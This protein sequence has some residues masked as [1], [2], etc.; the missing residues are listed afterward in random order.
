MRLSEWRKAAPTRDSMSNRVMA[1]LNPVLHDLGADPNPESWVVW[2][3]DPELRYAVLAPTPAGLISVAVRLT[4]PEAGPR[5]TAKLVRWSKLSV[6]ELAV[7]ASGGHR[8]VGV[9][10]EG[11]VLKGLDQEADRICEF[12]RGLIAGIDGRAPQ[13]IPVALVQA[14]PGRVRAAKRIAVS[15]AAATAVGSKPKSLALAKPKATAPKRLHA[16]PAARTRTASLAVQR[17]ADWTPSQPALR[18]GIPATTAPPS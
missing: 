11:Q 10:V 12:V 7:E 14:G 3:D 18:P 6:S 13:A 15:S 17:A 16:V 4:G 1:V 2:G 5:A 9:Q 8:I